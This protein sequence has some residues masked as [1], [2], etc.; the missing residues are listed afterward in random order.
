MDVLYVLHQ[1]KEYT[2][3]EYVQLIEALE[4]PADTDS[5]REEYTFT[6]NFLAEDN[7][8]GDHWWYEFT[9]VCC[10]DPTWYY[11]EHPLVRR[12]NV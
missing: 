2:F 8:V 5:Y 1:D 11:R 10:G 9:Q 7:I 6:V 12:D 4:L 3:E